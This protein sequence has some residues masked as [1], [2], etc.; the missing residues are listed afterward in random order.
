MLSLFI[1]ILVVGSMYGVTHSQVVIS[2]GSI[3]LVRKNERIE[4]IEIFIAIT[5]GTSSF[6]SDISMQIHALLLNTSMERTGNIPILFV[7]VKVGKLCKD[8][9]ALRC[10]TFVLDSSVDKQTFIKDTGR[11]NF[12][13]KSVKVRNI[14]NPM[15][16]IDSITLRELFCL[17]ISGK[18]AK[19]WYPRQPRGTEAL[20]IDS[21][22]PVYNEDYYIVF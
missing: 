2:N 22:S 8:F 13:P 18:D 17:S 20:F 7:F 12:R 1:I 6:F 4:S 9:E 16:I 11:R 19:I 15:V 14:H 3:T 5:V 10:S 21:R